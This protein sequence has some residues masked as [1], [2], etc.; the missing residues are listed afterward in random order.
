VRLPAGLASLRRFGFPH[1]LGLLDRLYGRALARHGVAWAST[2]NGLTW[3]LDLADASHRWIV[4]GV[5]EGDRWLRWLL[6][7]LSSG[8]VVVESG[9]NIGQTLLYYA[10]LPG[11]R[12]FAFE[13]NPIA[14]EWLDACLRRNPTLPVELVAAGL[15]NEAGDIELQLAGAQSTMVSSWYAA[16]GHRRLSVPVLR[17]DD[18]AAQHSLERIA[19]W[20]LDVEGY[21]PVALMGAERLLRA[22]AIGAIMVEASVSGYASVKQLLTQFGYRVYRLET[23]GSLAPGPERVT[24]IQNVIALP[25]GADPHMGVD[26]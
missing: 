8:G 16:S 6:E 19:F 4:Y 20:K 7:R 5:Y 21:E 12:T 1:K 15:S 23:D 24:V 2:S 25:E 22:A 3:K 14:R 10:H 11:V 17:L 26:V 9:A 18:F 13:P